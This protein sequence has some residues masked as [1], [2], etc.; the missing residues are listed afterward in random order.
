MN[1]I[2]NIALNI[3]AVFAYLP[4]MFLINDL[5]PLC[6]TQ[7]PKINANENVNNTALK[8]KKNP[9]NVVIAINVA[10]VCAGRDITQFVALPRY[11]DFGAKVAVFDAPEFRI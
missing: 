3:T 11:L 4:A 5:V 1:N 8:P 10:I 6:R 7:I 9:D 2:T